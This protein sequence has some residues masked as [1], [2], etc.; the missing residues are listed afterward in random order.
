MGNRGGNGELSL[1][2]RLS[3]VIPYSS[4]PIPH[5]LFRIPYSVLRIRDPTRMAER[6][7]LRSVVTR[8]LFDG[9]FVVVGGTL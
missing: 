7:R 8:R 5:S 6:R 2:V 4:L 3:S 1:T 9:G